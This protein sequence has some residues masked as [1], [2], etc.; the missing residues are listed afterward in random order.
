MHALHMPSIT[1]CMH[2]LW[3]F[4]GTPQPQPAPSY[5]ASL[6]PVDQLP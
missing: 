5:P 6:M 4:I 3:A 2:K 1:I